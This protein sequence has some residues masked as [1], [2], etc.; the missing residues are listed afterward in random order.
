MQQINPDSMTAIQPELTIGESVVWAG[1]PNGTVFFHKEDAFLIP[2]SLLWGG[3]AIFWELGAAG[4]WGSNSRSG[5]PW[6]FGMLWGIPFV[7][8]GQYV[9]WG[10]FFYT[11]WK[12]KR[13]YYAI[14]NRR[15]IVVQN[16]WNRQ[17]ASV[18]LDSLPTLIK[19][20]RSSG[21]GTLRFSQAES[22]WSGRRGWGAWGGMTVGNVPTFVDIDD[23]DYVYR[24]I[25]DLREKA[26]TSKVP[27]SA[28]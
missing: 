22:M 6:L 28:F 9:I 27:S 1:Q 26:R 7:L 15:V 3:F 23:L 4:F 13:T 20:G 11:A 12:K 2:F 14:T 5:N 25:S 18:Y 17:M 21:T 8:I 16:G 24:L 19:E 10:R